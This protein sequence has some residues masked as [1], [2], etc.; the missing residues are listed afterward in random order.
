[1]KHS[2]YKLFLIIMAFIYSTIGIVW[3]IIPSKKDLAI[4]VIETEVKQKTEEIKEKVKEQVREKIKIDIRKPLEQIKVDKPI[5]SWAYNLKDIDLDILMKKNIDMVVIDLSINDKNITK[6]Q[7]QKLKDSE[8]VVIAYV[9]LGEAEDYRE[10]WKD[11]WKTNKPSWIGNE[12]K[13]W[14]GNFQVKELMSKEWTD[15]SKSILTKTKELGFDGILVGGISTN[16][17]VNLYIARVT[18]FVK[19]N[20]SNFKVYVQDYFS[21]DIIDTID[22]VVK[23]GLSYSLFGVAN[24]NLEKDIEVLKSISSKGKKVFVIEFVTGTKWDIAKKKIDENNFIGVNGP[25]ELNKVF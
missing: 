21:N 1:M 7:I 24:K 5:T 13:L 8:K 15:I 20:D 6:E 11:E 19:K 23:Q 9:S 22:G 16:D 18:E 4:K 10:Y 25:L 2:T 12:S 3:L 14:K 17:Q